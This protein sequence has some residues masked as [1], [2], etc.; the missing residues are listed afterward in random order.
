VELGGQRSVQSSKSKDVQLTV[1]QVIDEL[2]EHGIGLSESDAMHRARRERT[3]C[4]ELNRIYWNKNIRTWVSTE[5]LPDCAH[6][7]GEADTFYHQI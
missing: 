2:L 6:L 1:E 4:T 5:H 7:S 3:E